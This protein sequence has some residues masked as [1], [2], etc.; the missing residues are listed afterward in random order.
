MK[1]TK[2]VIIDLEKKLKHFIFGSLK[3]L[4]DLTVTQATVPRQTLSRQY[5]CGINHHIHGYCSVL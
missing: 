1:P 4:L 5:F 2:L 3:I